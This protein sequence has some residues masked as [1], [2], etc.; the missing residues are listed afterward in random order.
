[1]AANA[2]YHEGELDVQEKVGVRAMSERVAAAIH[3]FLDDYVV[4][5]LF[6]QDFLV[7]SIADADGNHWAIPILGQ[8]GFA[9]AI[10]RKTMR[11]H[12]TRAQAD[13][14]WQH[15]Q[16]GASI[17][18]LG[19]VFSNRI[20]IRINGEVQSVDEE[21]VT[22]TVTQGYGNC[23]KYIQVRTIRDAKVPTS[24]YSEP[25]LSLTD[26]HEQIIAEA[27]TFFIASGHPEGGMDASHRGGEPGFAHVV[28]D[29]QILWPDYAGN[30]MFN[31]LGNIA[32][33]PPTGLLF[34][35]FEN[36]RV[37]QL[38]GRADILYDDERQNAFKGAQRLVRFEMIEGR[39]VLNGLGRRWELRDRSPHNPR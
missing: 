21:G 39:A 5:A 28:G 14:L 25:F 30:M 20:R 7:V 34:V 8:P 26:E 15:V 3:P 18:I 33:N 9:H 2:V 1:M 37:L 36:D 16:P 6:E 13:P 4:R 24:E 35:D 31:T 12:T 22:V 10:D 32:V 23:P 38:T 19:I 29:N 27:D 17:G 11:I